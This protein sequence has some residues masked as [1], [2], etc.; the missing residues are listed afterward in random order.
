MDVE[1]TMGAEDFSF[2]LQQVP[3]TYFFL[4]N[5]DISGTHRGE[6]H[7]LGPCTLHNATYDFNDNLIQIGAKFWKELVKS[8]LS[9]E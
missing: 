3:G 4:G 8:R 5:G 7:G 6:G 1:P 2:M 9:H